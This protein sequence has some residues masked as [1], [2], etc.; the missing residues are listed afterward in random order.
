[1]TFRNRFHSFVAIKFFV[2]YLCITSTGKLNISALFEIG[3]AGNDAVFDHRPI[4]DLHVAAND[5]QF[6]ALRMRLPNNGI[7]PD[8]CI[9]INDTIFHM[10]TAADHHI[11]HQHGITHHYSI[12]NT[13]TPLLARW[14]L[15]NNP[16]LRIETRKS[17]FDRKDEKK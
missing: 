11:A 9:F 1:M 14:L 16:D 8:D 5:R 17:M 7:F 2:R 12:N 10:C 4:F 15:E 3:S 6:S 13:V